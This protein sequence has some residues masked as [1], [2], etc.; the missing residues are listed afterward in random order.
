MLSSFQKRTAPDNI[1]VDNKDNIDNY[2]LINDI[3]KNI[4]KEDE[5]NNHVNNHE[6]IIKSFHEEEKDIF[7]KYSDKL[8]E[9]DS[10]KFNLI[11]KDEINLSNVSKKDSNPNIFS[12][13]QEKLII[14]FNDDKIQISDSTGMSIGEI[15]VENILKYLGSTYDHKNQ[16]M[17]FIDNSK[18]EEEKL[19]IEKFL[20]EIVSNSDQ[21]KVIDL[22]NYTNSPLMGN[23]EFLVKL[24]ESLYNFEK[25][26]LDYELKY[27]DEKNRYNIERIIKEFIYLL[28]NYTLKI[29]VVVSEELKE[30]KNKE[31]LKQQLI[32][33]SI[34]IT[35]RITQ[36]VQNQLSV[37]MK[38]NKSLEKFYLMN[39]KLK[40]IIDTKIDQISSNIQ[41]QNELIEKLNKE[42]G[43]EILQK[44]SSESNQSKIYTLSSEISEDEYSLSHEKN[45]DKL[46]SP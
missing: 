40:N 33:Y 14:N 25:H 22:K 34:G 46:F 36:F 2:D 10:D 16:F 41:K 7:Y 27:V 38:K 9:K 35:Y 12:K 39:F 23:I 3:N 31:N 13:G 17:K 26:K 21:K 18:F 6:E 24:N 20:F 29:I 44:V 28:L 5:N 37:V 32:K 4:N 15:Q 42:E 1:V 11:N 8:Q 43:K 30:K 45:L 19:L